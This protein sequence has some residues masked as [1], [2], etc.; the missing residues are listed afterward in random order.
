MDYAL[1]AD[2]NIGEVLPKRNFNTDTPYH[3]ARFF[4][5]FFN[6]VL[7]WLILVSILF[8]IVIDTFA[9]LRE[10]SQIIEYDK[11]NVCFICEKRRDQ[12]EKD[13][14]NF[15]QHTV[16][17]HNIWTYAEYMVGLKYMDR[18]ETNAINSYVLEL[19][20]NK[21]ISWFPSTSGPKESE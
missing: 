12:L 7:V 3:I 9:E 20:D 15:N 17:E 10:A 4:H 18:Q 21:Q 1:R 19:I 2:G 6:F 8:G 5:N 11:K 13:N 16:V 14:I